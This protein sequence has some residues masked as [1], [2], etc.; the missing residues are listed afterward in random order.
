VTELPELIVADA[1]AWQRWLADHHGDPQGVW[2]ILAKK[3]TDNPTSLAYDQA[4]DEA[5]CHGWIDGQTRKRDDATYMQRFTPRKRGSAWS[6][7]NVGL[8]EQLTAAGRMHP[9]GL[10]AI[11]RAKAD[12]RWAAAYAGPATIEVPGDL[13]EALDASPR[14][15]SMFDLLTS[16]NRYAILYRLNAAKRPDT[17]SRRIAEYVD[18]LA[19]GETIYPQ[20]RRLD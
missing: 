2:L 17:R 3:G 20:S 19:R 13:V 1:A 15:R 18:M 7:R 12:G 10:E 4:L 8:A 6:R 9:A 11:E 5:L 16:Q 14:A